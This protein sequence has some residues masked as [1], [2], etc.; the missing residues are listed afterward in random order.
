ME[1]YNFRTNPMKTHDI[2][3][4]RI[5]ITEVSHL[6][7]KIINTLKNDKISG[8]SVFRAIDGAGKSGSLSNSLLDFSLNLPIVVEFFDTKDKVSKALEHLYQL[9][10]PGHIIF[11]DAKMIIKD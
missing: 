5:Y 11:W 3:V 6:L 1:W 2:T 10:N 9:V 4:A 8:F 7:N